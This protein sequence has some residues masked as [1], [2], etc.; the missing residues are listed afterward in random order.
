MRFRLIALGAALL[1]LWG[2]A[3][4]MHLAANTWAAPPAF[5][6]WMLCFAASVVSAALGPP[7]W[8]L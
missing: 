1:V 4:V 2:G 6:T 7:P 3:F 5:V 8:T